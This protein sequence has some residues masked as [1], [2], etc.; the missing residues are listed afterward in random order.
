MTSQAVSIYEP[1]SVT[2]YAGEDRTIELGEETRLTGQVFPYF[3][4]LLQ[5]TPSDSLSNPTEIATSAQPTSTTLYNLI[6]TDTI[7]G[8]V[9]VDDVL[10]QVDKVRNIYI[11]N[12]FSPN[13]DGNNDH[14]Y[15]FAGNGVRRV[16]DF[17]IFDRWGEVIYEAEN[18]P[19]NTFKHGWDGTFKGQAMN[20]GV[21]VYFAEVE[22]I[23]NEVIHY[24]GDVT[25]LK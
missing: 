18:F 5:W 8:C 3:G 22:F 16:L 14:F 24:N 1:P 21:F 9:I 25:L 12:A 11:P 17:K 20:P 4:Q 13:A 6:V 23:D 7:S 10:V 15:I 19:P 2:V